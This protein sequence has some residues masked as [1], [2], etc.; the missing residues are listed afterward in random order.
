VWL[1]YGIIPVCF[2]Y[3]VQ[4]LSFGG[5]PFLLSWAVGLLSVNILVVNNYRDYE[6]DQAV[7]KRTTIVLYGR[8]FGRLLYIGNGIGA[9]AFTLPLLLKATWWMHLLYIGFFLLF[10]H[11]WHELSR[12]RG[13]A[14]NHTL[15]HTARNVFL[16]TLL[17]ILELLLQ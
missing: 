14:L 3:Y 4:A 10:L 2:T 16:Y 12:F 15:A 9:M 7:G 11:T 1:F 5:L 17:M 13:R 6:Q 8:R